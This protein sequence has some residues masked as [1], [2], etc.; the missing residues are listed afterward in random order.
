MPA[1]YDTL[2]AIIFE[3]L[4]E[5]HPAVKQVFD[6]EMKA[7][8]F[9]RVES[10]SCCASILFTRIPAADCSMA[11]ISRCVAHGRRTI[12]LPRSALLGRTEPENPNS[13]RSSPRYSRRYF[14]H[15]L[16][17]KSTLR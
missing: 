11:S 8:C 14:M 5:H 13:Y 6:P 10:S 17:W 3:L 7:M 16:R 15:A 4:S 9:E 12:T 2:Q 1:S